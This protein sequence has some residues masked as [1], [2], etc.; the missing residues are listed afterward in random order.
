VRA[1]DVGSTTIGLSLVAPDGQALT[2]RPITMT[3]TA[4]HFGTL[5]L[6]VLALALGVF[7]V[8][9]AMRAIRRGRTPPGGGPVGAS[10]QDAPAGT[11]TAGHEQPEETD[12]VGHDRAES[13]EAGTDHV[14]TEDA[15]DYA[16]VP[17]WADRR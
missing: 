14:L 13:G 7:V 15:D 8:T 1:A 6:T 12:N 9:S 2:S 3:V 17:G 16:R 10:G 11:G 5:G 4:T